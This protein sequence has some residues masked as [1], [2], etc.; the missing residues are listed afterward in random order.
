MGL[1]FEYGS[2]DSIN[3]INTEFGAKIQNT[4]SN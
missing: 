2:K 1:N 3:Q 4:D